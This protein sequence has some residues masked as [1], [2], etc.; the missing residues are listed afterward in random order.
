MGS[1]VAMTI[2]CLV[3]Y[4]TFEVCQIMMMYFF[5]RM[6]LREA[7]QRRRGLYRLA[8]SLLQHSSRPQNNRVLGV[9]L[10]SQASSSCGTSGSTKGQPQMIDILGKPYATDEWTN[11][12]PSIISKVGF[13][14]H[15][16]KYHPINLIRQRIVNYF[17]KRFE[18][19]VGNP[20]FAVF[21]SISP[22]VTVQQNF[23]SLLVPANHISRSK[24]DTYYINKDELLRAHTSAHQD[25]LIRM[26]FDAFLAVGDVYRRDEIDRSH[27]PI[28][29]Q[30]DGVRLITKDQVSSHIETIKH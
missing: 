26:G 10:C 15:N 16:R 18:N 13:N 3:N 9:S 6:V 24:S 7:I 27:Y 29:H 1:I 19:H 25:E 20:M 5:F 2:I 8:H 23:D 12:T 4:V 21:D 30:M 17:Y 22:V 14:L 11:V 28:F